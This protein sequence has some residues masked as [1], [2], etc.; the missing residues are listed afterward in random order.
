[1]KIIL[2]IGIVGATLI[3]LFWEK[4]EP[5]WNDLKE[6]ISSAIEK[7]NNIIDKFKSTYKDC[8][9]LE[10]YVNKTLELIDFKKIFKEGFLVL[11]SWLGTQISTMLD[12]PIKFVVDHVKKVWE[13]FKKFGDDLWTDIKNL[14]Q[15]GKEGNELTEAEIAKQN[16]EL[17]AK[18]IA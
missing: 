13:D 4:I 1:M 14:F 7:A 8:D 10:D 5:I 6:K 9:S 15:K 17:A 18:N 2:A 3:A 16:E 11:I 12:K